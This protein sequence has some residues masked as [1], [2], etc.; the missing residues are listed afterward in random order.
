MEGYIDDNEVDDSEF[1]NNLMHQIK[2]DSFDYNQTYTQVWRKQLKAGD[3]ID[4]SLEIPRSQ[5]DFEW[6]QAKL[7]SVGIDEILQLD[8]IY[9]KWQQQT[10]ISMWSI[11]IEQFGIHTKDLYEQKD[12]FQIMMQVDINDT[13][14][15]YR[16]TILDIQERKEQ[17]SRN[18]IKMAFIGYRIYCEQGKKEDDMGSFDG[19]NTITGEC[20]INSLKWNRY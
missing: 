17:Y 13:M 14:I 16:S 1:K 7:L 11:K 4:V 2:S 18:V 12:K 8:F 9:D 3:M 19:C 10:R 15:W 20:K 5:G 6:V